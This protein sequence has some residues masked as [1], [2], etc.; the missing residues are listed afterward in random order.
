M[1]SARIDELIALATLGELSSDE[2]RELDDAVRNEPALAAELDE[3]LHNAAALQQPHAQAPPAALR[4][5]VL[6]AISTTP[7]EGVD[8]PAPIAH[9]ESTPAVSLEDRRTRRR[10]GPSLVAAAA[11]ALF[12]VG[13]LVAVVSNETGIDPV[14]AVI[15]A[16]DATSRPLAGEIGNLTVVYSASLEALVVE[17][18]GVPVLDEASTYQLWLVG[19]D[20]ATS[21]GVFRPDDDG[22]VAQRFGDADP[23]D[24]VLGVTREPAGGSESPTLPILA[25]A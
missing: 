20:G 23:T 6:A 21:V 9:P 18:D 3:A 2:R 14:A 5:S 17:G 25:S 16:S 7:Q 24:F 11:V 19:D 1:T 13:G 12:A 4:E 8:G 10:F 15:E 22:S